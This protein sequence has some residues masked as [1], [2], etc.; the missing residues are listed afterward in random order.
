MA[1]N[2][3]DPDRLDRLEGLV[4]VLFNRHLEFEEEHKRLLTA[5]VVPT[6][7]MNKLD[8][9]LDRIAEIQAEGAQRMNALIAIV[10]E[11]IRNR[12]PQP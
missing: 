3:H 1:N 11:I 4:E 8:L 9:R 12:P 7:R 6:D 2:G 5:Q 10:D